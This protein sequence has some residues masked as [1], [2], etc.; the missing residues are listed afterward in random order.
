MSLGGPVETKKAICRSLTN[1]VKASPLKDAI[2]PKAFFMML[3]ANFAVL[4]HGGR[5]N[6]GP[7][8]DAL[9][10]QH[11]PELLFGMFLKFQEAIEALGLA[12][13]QPPNVSGLSDH[14]K[15]SYVIHFIGGEP[16]RTWSEESTGITP[17]MSLETVQDGAPPPISLS[18]NDLKP[19][20]PEDLRRRV[21]QAVVAAFRTTPLGQKLEAAK[22]GFWIDSN[23]EALCDGF[24]F[25]VNALYHALR[26]LGEVAESDVYLATVHL[27]EP[28]AALSLRVIEPQLELDPTLREAIERGVRAGNE[29]PAPTV[30]AD[31][32]PA[33]ETPPTGEKPPKAERWGF[34]KGKLE[35]SARAARMIRIG[36]YAVLFIACVTYG[37]L[38]R[39]N[40]GLDTQDFAVPL[41][42]AELVR[43][44]F[45]AVIDETRWFA[46]RWSDRQSAVRQME[47]QLKERGW[48]GSA[49]IRDASAHLVM[50]GSGAR[51]HPA[52]FMIKDRLPKDDPTV[53]KDLEML[54]PDRA[55]RAPADAAKDAPAMTTP[56]GASAKA[57]APP[58]DK[59]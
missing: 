38:V 32:A 10:Q 44:T 16:P 52:P 37:W 42:H 34:G 27:R 31:K 41:L 57:A 21:T 36:V 20:I 28:L 22:L 33:K 6:L 47:A 7:L 25:D 53:P 11:P 24:A 23:F 4:Y 12:V 59:D 56:E 29:P 17:L 55:N 26:E 45:A 46:L 2:D 54:N 39:P 40:R 49:Q 50:A 30:P 5:L 19:L 58:P 3:N 14:Q 48:I 9:S 43:G 18:T 35:K 13:A 51:L 1:V 15:E 8:W